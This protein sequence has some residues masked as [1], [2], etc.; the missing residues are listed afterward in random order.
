MEESL[1]LISS[2]IC[3]TFAEEI[4]YC[5]FQVILQGKRTGKKIRQLP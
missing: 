4:I 1:N 3:L 2:V 5:I